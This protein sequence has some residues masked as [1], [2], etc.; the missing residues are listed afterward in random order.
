MIAAHLLSIKS[1]TNADPF[2][3][4]VTRTFA[5]SAYL[6]L[7]LAVII[8][9]VRSI[10]RVTGERVSWMLDELHIILAVLSG[11]LLAGH[12]LGLVFDP[13]L[14]FGLNNI[15]FPGDQPIAPFAVNLGV[16]GMYALVALLLTSALRRSIPY[17]A[18]RAV[19]YISFVAFIL[20]TLHGWIVGSDA[21]TDW[22]PAIYVGCSGAVGFLS[23]VRLLTDGTP[24]TSARA[25]SDRAKT[26]LIVALVIVCFGSFVIYGIEKVL[27][28]SA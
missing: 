27:F 13:F 3:W 28:V 5:V 15:L 21:S 8:G 10:A 6:A 9:T 26:S 23:L 4:Y 1:S 11:F 17:S 16:F 22:M 2:L 7:T 19:H 12:L 20:V 18:W 24:S 25:S 14:T